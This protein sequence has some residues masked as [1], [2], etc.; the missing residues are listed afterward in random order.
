[1]VLSGGNVD[2]LSLGYPWLRER[3]AECAPVGTRPKPA[4]MQRVL[5]AQQV[6]AR[7]RPIDC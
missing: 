6:H 5:C 4:A 3:A 2:W 1:M 7:K